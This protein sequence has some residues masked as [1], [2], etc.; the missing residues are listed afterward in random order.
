[1]TSI[2]ES[3]YRSLKEFDIDGGPVEFT[4]EER[5]ARENG[6]TREYARRVVQEYKRFVFLSATAGHPITPSEEVDQ[7]WHLHMTF[8]DSYWDG[9]CPLLPRPLRHNPTKGGA[10]ESAKFIDWYEKT[11]ASYRRLLGEEPPADIWPSSE[12]RFGPDRFV[13]VNLAENWVVPK[14]RLADV[15]KIAALLAIFSVTLAGCTVLAQASTNSGLYI[16]LVLVG[17]V[18]LLA[19]IGLMS[20]QGE[21]RGH[22]SGQDG[23]GGGGCGSG[24]GS[25]NESGD[26][27]CGSS[28]CGGGC[29]GGCSS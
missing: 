28:G 11:K 20:K 12:K 10:Q 8:T 27:G 26:S 2:E 3:L 21:K 29:G 4:F 17:V 9:M 7:A 25:N 13:R 16:V 23:C 14:T 6:W 22:S 24:C 15:G 5:L 18:V 1:M 19:L